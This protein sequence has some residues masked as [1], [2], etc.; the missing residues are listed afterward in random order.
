MTTAP[1][2]AAQA[3]TMIATLQAKRAGLVQ[4]IDGSTFRRKGLAVAAEFGDVD[5]RDELGEIEAEEA[6]AKASIAQL[7]LVVAEVENMRD[8]LHAQEANKLDIRNAIELDEAIAGLLEIDDECDQALDHARDLL[9]KRA[10]FKREQAQILRRIPGKM[11]GAMLGREREVEAALQ[12]YFSEYLN[13]GK[14]YGSTRIA[15]GDSR[16]YGKQSPHQIERGPRTLT[17]FQKAMQREIGSRS[18]PIS[19]ATPRQGEPVQARCAAARPGRCE[20]AVRRTGARPRGQ[21]PGD[22]GSVDRRDKFA[23]CA[24]S[25]PALATR[26]VRFIQQHTGIQL[27]AHDRITGQQREPHCHQI[28]QRQSHPAGNSAVS[29]SHGGA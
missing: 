4:T 6:A 13:A 9:A 29:R 18:A 21:H 22:A 15:D 26:I 1:K 3:R 24:Q 5:A 28:R 10:D 14:S 27:N 16:Y 8:A 2:T 23:L 11:I 12:S 25:W 20:A 7:D 19:I 17:P